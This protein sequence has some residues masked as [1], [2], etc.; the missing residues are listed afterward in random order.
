MEEIRKIEHDL[1]DQSD[2]LRLQEEYLV[3][4]ER[5]NECLELLKEHN[6]AKRPRLSIGI[7]QSLIASIATLESLKYSLR[8]RFIHEGAGH[9][10]TG[11]I[12]HDIDSA[13][14][15]RIL[16]GAVM[17]SNYIEPLSFLQDAREIVLE[18]VRNALGKHKSLKVNAVFNGE[19]VTG[20]QRSRKSVGTKNCEIVYATDLEE[21]YELCIVG[22]ILT[23]LEEFQERDSGWALSRILN[24]T[25]CYSINKF[26]PLH[27]GCQINIPRE[28]AL[29]K[30][31]INVHSK[32]NACFAWSVMAA[33]YPATA[34]SNRQSSYP[35]YTNVLNF[36]D[37]EFPMLLNQI[38]RFEKLN[39]IS[40]NVYGFEDLREEKKRVK[41][42]F[43]LRITNQKRNRHVNLLYIQDQTDSIVGHYVWIKNLSRLVSAQLS[44]NAHMKFICDRCLHYFP[45]NERLRAHERDCAELN[46]C[47]IVLP[48]E[49]DKWL[50]FGNYIWKEPIPF[51]V[52]A[53]LECTLEKMED[54]GEG[55]LQ[56]HR[57]FSI[58][59]YVQ[60]ALFI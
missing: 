16:T 37:I 4:E 47:A 20:D 58:A 56:S 13:F 33:L 38:T 24:L 41:S 36:E 51:V 9:A 45:S 14:K 7:Q 50:S 49:D 32:D 55:K 28:I 1:W 3:W 23:S 31:T 29:K 57:V 52:Y 39:D 46:R 60:C 2:R 10:S 48:T 26:N 34:H 54:C 40:I 6:R 30:A 11:L 21:M 8:R 19:F 42:F 15:G 12:W 35:E 17:N 44:K 25:V 22:P 59:Y 27:A 43:P 53:D 5:C 18:K